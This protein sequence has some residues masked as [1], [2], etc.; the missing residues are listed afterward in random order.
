MI[1]I[2]DH[3]QLSLLTITKHHE[4]ATTESCTASDL[5][6]ECE[7]T[8]HFRVFL[9]LAFNILKATVNHELSIMKWVNVYVSRWLAQSQLWSSSSVIKR[10]T[11]HRRPSPADWNHERFRLLKCWL[12]SFVVQAPGKH[13]PKAIVATVAKPT[14]NFP[15]KSTTPSATPWKYSL[16]GGCNP[17]ENDSQSTIY[18]WGKTKKCI[19]TTHIHQPLAP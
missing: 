17:S 2:L 5:E 14:I 9:I 11:G 15:Q 1:V 13:N 4:W 7:G 19:K 10:I 16:V 18:D 12:C 8:Q 6:R 3:Y